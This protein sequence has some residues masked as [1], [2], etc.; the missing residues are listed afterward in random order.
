MLYSQYLQE[1]WLDEDSPTTGYPFSLPVVTSLRRCR[2][3]FHPKVTFLVGENGSG[4]ST[5]MEAMALLLGFNPEGGNKNLRFST[6]D[7]H[8]DLR[9]HLRLAKGRRERRGY[10]FRAESAYNVLSAQDDVDENL[11]HGFSLHQESHGESFLTLAVNRFGAEGLFLLD[12]PE[13]ALSP[14]RQLTVL[15]LLHQSIEAGSQYVIAT[16]S[17]ILMAYPDAWIYQLDESGLQRIGYD[18]CE[19]VTITRDFLASPQRM[20]RHLFAE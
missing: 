14:A 2:L 19:N 17:P 4:K 20:M 7:T 13:S 10:F 12:E 1:V 6:R 15:A 9:L 16:H 5:L 3:R 11:K 8:S 18:E